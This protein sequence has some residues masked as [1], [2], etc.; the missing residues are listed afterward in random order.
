MS[1]YGWYKQDG[2]LKIQWDTDENTRKIEE[3]KAYLMKG[4][5]C[6][7][8]CTTRRCRCKKGDLQCGPSCQ[9]INCQNITDREAQKSQSE[10]HQS[11]EE[12]V[13]QEIMDEG[14]DGEHDMENIESEEQDA[15]EDYR[16]PEDIAEVMEA[17]FGI[18]QME[19]EE[20]E[21]NMDTDSDSD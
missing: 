16:L 14:E 17:I 18:E 7:T 6:K 21:Y 2:Q 12:E 15:E 3:N 1:D 9:C 19:G 5:K 11:G 10:V 13:H 20:T 8:G 4:C